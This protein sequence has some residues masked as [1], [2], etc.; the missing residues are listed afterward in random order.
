MVSS[1]SL[2]KAQ[3]VFDALRSFPSG[4]QTTA[5]AAGDFDE[6]GNLDV[7]AANFGS[8]TVFVYRGDGTGNLSHASTLTTGPYPGCLVLG[9]FNEDGHIDV[10]VHGYGELR[11][12]FSGDGTGR[13]NGPFDFVAGYDSR[14]ATAVDVNEDGHLDLVDA[15][16]SDVTILL[17]DGRGG[18]GPP[19]DLGV[20]QIGQI[21]SVAVA[22]FDHDGHLDIATAVWWGM[23]N[24]PNDV[25]IHRGFG[26]GAFELAGHHSTIGSNVLDIAAADL[27]EDG[28]IDLG[29]LHGE[30]GLQVFLGDGTGGFSNG[31]VY[32]AGQ[33]SRRLRFADLDQNH[34]LDAI[35]GSM[36]HP[37]A[38]VAV[39]LGDGSGGFENT[40]YFDTGLSVAGIETG[41]IDCDHQIDVMLAT[42]DYESTDPLSSGT[43]GVL[44]NRTHAGVPCLELTAITP[45]KG[46]ESG[47]ELVRLVGRG[48]TSPAQAT[49]V[50]FGEVEASVVNITPCQITVRTPP[51]SGLVDVTITNAIGTSTLGASYQFLPPYLAARLGNVNVGHGDREDV[52]LVNAVVGDPVT[53]QSVLSILSPVSVVVLPPTTRTTAR[54]VLYGWIGL[55]DATTA[56]GLPRTL[57]FMVFPPPFVARQPQPRVIWN[58]AGHPGILGLP[59]IASRPAPSLVIRTTG[60]PVPSTV[61]LQG[62]IEDDASQSAGWS[63]TNAVVVEFR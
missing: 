57:G 24:R 47:R 44:L 42:I 62:L 3:V 5:L 16:G 32:P 50:T 18:F 36:W 19:R 28:N 41:D 25:F 46:S 29:V 53:R 1:S 49:T 6:D 8:G 9:D 22:D 39:L 33:L 54:F 37:P 52:L 10:V 58:N 21:S 48:F 31:G 35:I 27:N 60:S 59:T 61:A 30:A 12:F 34:H 40:M 20:P 11:S 45:S 13:F 7:M 56:A 38:T 26:D 15:R 4:Q 51:R 55:P 63:V 17:G 2:A 23:G 14:S 43:I